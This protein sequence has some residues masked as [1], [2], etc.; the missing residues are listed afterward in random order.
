MESQNA[1][2]SHTGVNVREGSLDSVE[3]MTGK[4]SS[5]NPQIGALSR[6]CSTA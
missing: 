4:D 5:R 1:Q 3:K 6:P 2:E